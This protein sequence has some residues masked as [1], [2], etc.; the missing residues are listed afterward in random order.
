MNQPITRSALFAVLL[1]FSIL[2]LVNC[3]N[4][5]P[6]GSSPPEITGFSPASGEAGTLVIINGN[7]FSE[8]ILDNQVIFNETPANI[9]EATTVS[10]TVTVPSSAA[11]GKIHIAVNGRTATSS[12]DFVVLSGTD[13]P[14]GPAGPAPDIDSISPLYGVPGTLVNIYG[15]RFGP[16]GNE[17]FFKGTKATVVSQTGTLITATVPQGA[18]SGR[19]TV[20]YSGG[21]GYSTD[22]FD[23][24]KDIPRDGLVAFY[25]F[26]ASASDVSGNDLHGSVTGAAPAEDRFGKSNQ[27]Y[28]FDGVDDFIS[29]GNPLLLQISN[30]ITVSGWVN[31]NAYNGSSSQAIITKIFFNPD[32]GY[33]PW[34]GYH[35]DQDF[36]GNGDPS[37]SKFIFSANEMEVTSYSGSYVGSG[38]SLNDWIFFALVIDNTSWKFYQDGELTEEVDGSIALLEDGSLGDFVL[39]KYSSGFF[40]D[41]RIDDVAVYDRPLTGEEVTQ[42]FEQTVSKY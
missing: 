37:F 7:H 3:Q 31:I 11:T 5:D 14:T 41:G 33:N 1:L 9:K 34:R 36:Y 19:I 24:L 30:Q 13:S 16:S 21:S 2:F 18:A 20:T 26:N 27:A 6:A 29:M 23:V 22:E 28:S 42:L 25:P 10:L 4:D 12:T 35:I 38:V 40:F 8:N 32:K 39:G 15:S 17:V